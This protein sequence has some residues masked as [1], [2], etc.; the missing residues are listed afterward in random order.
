DRHELDQRLVVPRDDD[1]LALERL[2][3]ERRELRLGLG[4]VEVFRRVLRVLHMVILDDH[5]LRRQRLS[6]R[7][8]Q[9]GRRGPRGWIR[10]SRCGENS[11]SRPTASPSSP[12]TASSPPPPSRRPPRASRAISRAAAPSTAGAWRSWSRRASPTSSSRAASGS[13]AA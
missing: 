12:P 8:R 4:D 13:P 11:A 10:W 9:G 6:V 3:H 7:R 5:T 1:L 2:A